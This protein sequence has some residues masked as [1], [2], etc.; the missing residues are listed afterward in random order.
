MKDANGVKWL[1]V[2]ELDAALDKL[3]ADAMVCVNNMGNLF[4]VTTDGKTFFVDF[5][6]GDVVR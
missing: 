3:P 6:F 2:A 5:L 1:T 4:G